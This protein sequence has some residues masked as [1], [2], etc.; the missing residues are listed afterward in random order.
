MSGTTRQVSAGTKGPSA[1]L[2]REGG[3]VAA[4]NIGA[5]TKFFDYLRIQGYAVVADHEALDDATLLG[6]LRAALEL[7]GSQPIQRCRT[8]S[9]Q[10][11]RAVEFVIDVLSDTVGAVEGGVLSVWFAGGVSRFAMAGLLHQARAH[12]L[13]TMLPAFKESIHRLAEAE[14]RRP[15]LLDIGGRA[16]SR[17]QK[18]EEYPHCDVTVFDIIADP[19]VDVVGDAHEMSRH[20]PAD[21]FDFAMSLSVFE[22]LLMP[23]KVA[24]EMNRVMRTGGIA[25]VY[26]HQTV[27][28]HDLPWDFLRF[29]SHSW[30]GM[31]NA[32]TGFEIIQT[33]M[34]Y[35]VHVVPS[36]FP[37]P[38]VNAEQTGGFMASTVMARKVGPSRVDWPV[39]LGEVVNTMYP[40]Y[41]DISEESPAG[42]RA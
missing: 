5:C 30:A 18:S 25:F 23:W 2:P 19:G 31:F 4:V 17:I 15:L 42:A 39:P 33:D 9:V 32:H 7:G 24:V 27:A 28:L 34:S 3:P 21:H 38:P 6:G 8:V 35:L 10:P 20:L 1:R 22:H 16:R 37:D 12:D 36:V 29:S 41:N 26:S 11:N 13:R 40:T 14:G